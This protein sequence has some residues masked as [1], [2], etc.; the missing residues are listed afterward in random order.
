MS[1][2]ELG[3]KFSCAPI[4][5]RGCWG[6]K[7][8]KIF[9]FFSRLIENQNLYNISK[10][11]PP[12]SIRRA[13]E[14][15]SSRFDLKKVLFLPYL[16]SKLDYE[17]E[18]WYIHLLGALDAPFGGLDF[19]AKFPPLAA[20]KKRFFWSGFFISIIFWVFSSHNSPPNCASKLKFVIYI[21]K[22]FYICLLGFPTF[23]GQNSVMPQFRGGSA[24]GSKPQNL[25]LYNPIDR[26]SKVV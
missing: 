23:L 3:S 11:Q 13:D 14:E 26:K 12:K 20:P 6:V 17:V 16:P 2:D 5:G 15:I 25:P 18:I 24:E 22:K 4:W 1:G 19:S 8:A 21:E 10:N 7:N 9:P